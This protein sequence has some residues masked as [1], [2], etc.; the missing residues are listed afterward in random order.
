M[1][2]E[3]QGL[4][5]RIH[6]EGLS[7][8]DQQKSEII[9]AAKEEAKSIIAKAK[10]E[11]DV[12]IKNAKT[13]EEANVAKG[14]ATLSQASRDILVQ[15]KN[16]MS[17]RIDK[18]VKA[19]IKDVMTP[20]FMGKIISE[21]TSKYL[22][23]DS[24]AELTLETMVAPADLEKMEKLIKGS[25]T[26]SFKN[27]PKIFSDHDIDSGLKINV[28]GDDAFFDFTDEAF[29][30]LICGYAGPRFTEYFTEQS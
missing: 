6:E 12:I 24:K 25:L 15:L 21:M 26:A 19:S 2:E 11:A 17:K 30:E 18:V 14:K 22:Q 4:L 7:K 3:L 27:D 29:A 13:E 23:S 1:A 5:K 16:E 8:A 28:K 10:A 9:A 20:E